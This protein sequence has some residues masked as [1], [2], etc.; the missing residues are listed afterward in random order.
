MLTRTLIEYGLRPHEATL[1]ASRIP[2]FLFLVL[3]FLLAAPAAA[4][5]SG[6]ATMPS[7]AGVA[8]SACTLPLPWSPE[9]EIAM[10]MADA[11]GRAGLQARMLAEALASYLQTR[12]KLVGPE[13]ALLENLDAYDGLVVFGNGRFSD[14]DTV[15]SA[16]EGAGLIGVPVAWIGLGGEQFERQLGLHFADPARVPELGEIDAIRHGEIEIATGE[17]QFAPLLADNLA[18]RVTV[19]ADA[20]GAPVVV[21][22]KNLAYVGYYPFNGLTGRLPFVA[23]VEAVSRLFGRHPED[24][25][26][27]LRLEDSSASRYPAGSAVFPEVTQMLLERGVFMHLGI[28]PEDVAQGPDIVEPPVLDDIGDARDVV[29]LAFQHPN[30]VELV[31][32]GLRHYRPDARNTCTESGCAWEFFTDDDEVMGAEAA[33][34]FARERLAAG[35]DLIARHLWEPRVFEA[36]HYVMSPAQ[37][38]VAEE[39]YALILHAPWTFEGE[40]GDLFVPWFTR[41]TPTVYGP[42]DVGFVAYDEPA[43][44]EHILA[45][46]DE[47]GR[48]LPDPVVTVFFHPFM[49][50]AEGRE[51]DLERLISGIEA[52]GWRFISACDEL[53]RAK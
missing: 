24:R 40:F 53:T 17:I 20:D 2:A 19:L 34:A 7:P 52:R 8:G 3:A 51:G 45:R 26:V 48:L 39:T 32:H 28:I 42:S 12:V 16:L 18:A 33:A 49:H 15:V 30:A 25:R 10:L 43:S 4:Q 9:H 6:D 37:A 46:L 13:D 44:V 14:P 21:A 36:P 23:A 35:R 1:P 29:R 38:R 11:E 27:I 22:G 41:R 50:H 47:T 5:T 31:Q